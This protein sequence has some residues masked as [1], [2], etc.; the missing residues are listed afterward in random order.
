MYV[1][2]TYTYYGPGSV[3]RDTRTGVFR[4]SAAP[5]WHVFQAVS[6]LCLLMYLLNL[7]SSLFSIFHPLDASGFPGNHLSITLYLPCLPLTAPG[8]FPGA[9][10]TMS[11][12]GHPQ[13]SP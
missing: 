7:F 9:A 1:A 2:Q 4:D 13:A 12:S 11:G 10:G 6:L 8:I 5:C 3:H